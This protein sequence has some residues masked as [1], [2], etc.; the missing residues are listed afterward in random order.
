[1]MHL[2][3]ELLQGIRSDPENLSI[4]LVAAD[5]FEEHGQPERAEFIRIQCDLESNPPEEIGYTGIT[6]P[7]FREMACDEMLQEFES[8][9]LKDSPLLWAGWQ[10]NSTWVPSFEWDWRRGFVEEVRG[11]LAD[12][13]G[14]VCDRCKGMSG[15]AYGE[16]N[17]CPYCEGRVEIGSHGPE[18]LRSQPVLT[19]RTEKNPVYYSSFPR[20]HYRKMGG[21]CSWASGDIP[22]EI[23]AILYPGGESVIHADGDD[24]QSALSAALIRW[25]L[26]KIQQ[27]C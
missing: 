24:A 26:N 9:W 23:M 17:P 21:G 27:L 2:P 13:Y 19:V 14:G 20:S 6:G 12:W 7:C 18:I 25:A 10:A 16:N 4:R 22:D 8:A 1:M 5:F 15:M 3:P 11:T